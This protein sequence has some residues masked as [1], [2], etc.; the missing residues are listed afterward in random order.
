VLT[1]RDPAALAPDG[2]VDAGAI[3][4]GAGLP[5]DAEDVI[6]TIVTSAAINVAAHRRPRVNSPSSPS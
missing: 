1:P 2:S 4:T 3:R 5:A 6:A